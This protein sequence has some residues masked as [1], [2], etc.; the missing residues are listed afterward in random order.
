MEVIQVTIIMTTATMFMTHN[1]EI[2]Q[3]L[4]AAKE[5]EDHHYHH[6]H[7]HRRHHHH[8]HYHYQHCEVKQSNNINSKAMKMLNHR[9]EGNS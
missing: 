6:H 1:K 8:H 5:E 7:H 3:L 4:H 9:N 2:K